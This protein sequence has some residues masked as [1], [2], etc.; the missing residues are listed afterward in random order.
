MDRVFQT[1]NKIT[2]DEFVIQDDLMLTPIAA[3]FT[4]KKL[5]LL[6][7]KTD[8]SGS[9]LVTELAGPAWTPSINGWSGIDIIGPAVAKHGFVLLTG[10]G[11]FLYKDRLPAIKGIE[12]GLAAEK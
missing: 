8:A 6:F 1:K 9:E 11:G 3:K 7:V 5:V 12:K 10:F 2:M 4:G